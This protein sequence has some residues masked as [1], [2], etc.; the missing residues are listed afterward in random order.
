MLEN[1]FPFFCFCTI[2]VYIITTSLIGLHW[3]ARFNILA[4]IY[5][6]ISDILDAW[7][8][9]NFDHHTGWFNPKCQLT[10]M[11]KSVPIKMVSSYHQSATRCEANGN[12]FICQCHPTGTQNMVK[13]WDAKITL[14]NMENQLGKYNERQMA[15]L[16]CFILLSYYKFRHTGCWR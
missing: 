12:P 15:P 16:I 3:L 2:V 14:G 7:I 11:A 13:D 4:Y 10:E 6:I 5:E 8:E 9:I 1:W